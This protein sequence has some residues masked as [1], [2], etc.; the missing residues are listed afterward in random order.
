MGGGIWATWGDGGACNAGLLDE[1]FVKEGVE[2]AEI[3]GDMLRDAGADDI[4]VVVA[5]L[6]G[7]SRRGTNENLGFTFGGGGLLGRCAKSGGCQPLDLGIMGNC[8]DVSERGIRNVSADGEVYVGDVTGDGDDIG[9]VLSSDR[10]GNRPTGTLERYCLAG[11]P[12]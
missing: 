7:V 4:G 6:G 9:L 2:S 1:L 10:R 12:V 11:F 5:E 3:I 8:A